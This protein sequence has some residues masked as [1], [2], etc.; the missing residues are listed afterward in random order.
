M[1]FLA[2]ESCDSRVVA[3][4]REAGFNVRSALDFAPAGSDDE[5]VMAV[6]RDEARVLL[7]EDRDFGR[8]VYAECGATAGVLY[9]RTRPQERA[10]Q[11]ARV[12]ALVQH[13]GDRL[14]G[15]FVVLR[16]NR[17]RWGRSPPG[18]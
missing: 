9:M 12:V 11:P 4:L 2:D 13:L 14:R 15:A 17:V 7:T 10:R 5:V 3:A 18:R 6:A 1:R 16:G 8:L